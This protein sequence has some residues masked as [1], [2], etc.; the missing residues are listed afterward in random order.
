MA[1]RN[2][3]LTGWVGYLDKAPRRRI[4]R[5]QIM[6]PEDEVLAFEQVAFAGLRGQMRVLRTGGPGQLHHFLVYSGESGRQEPASAEMPE[7]HYA[8]VVGSTIP[9]MALFDAIGQ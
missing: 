2:S 7:G 5:F 1:T 8:A 3:G 6:R 4:N 9:R